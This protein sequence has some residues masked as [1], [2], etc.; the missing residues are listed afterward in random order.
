MDDG[1]SKYDLLVVGGGVNGAG[2][3]RDAAGRGLRTLLCEQHDLAAHTSSASTKLIHGGLRYLEFYDFRLVRKSLREREIVL[4]SAPHIVRPMRFVLPHDAHLRPAWMIRAGLFLYDHLARRR[5]L[6]GSEGVNLRRHPA[7]APLAARYTKG[8]V[9][10]DAWVD[11]ARLVVITAMD[12]RAHGARILTRTRCTRLERDGNRWLATLLRADGSEMHVEASAVVN[13]TGPWVD[14]FLDGSTPVPARRHPRIVKGSHI[15]VP[16]LFDHDFAYIFQAPDRRIVFAIPYEHEY[17]LIGTT[18]RDYKDDLAT[19]A[20]ETPEVDYLLAMANRYFQR[21][22]ARSDVRWSF[23]GLRPLLADPADVATSVTRDYV[24]DVEGHGPPLLSIYGGKL[25]TYRRLA[26]DVLDMLA[27]R[28]GWSREHWTAA[29]T[30]PGGDMAGGDF[31]T[32]RDELRK[33]YP[34]LPATL[35]DRLAAAYGTRVDR[36]LGV[37]RS[38]LELGEEVLPGLHQREIEYLRSEEWAVTAEDILYRRS[39]LALHLPADAAARLDD[40]LTRHPRSDS[41]RPALV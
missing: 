28:L 1:R 26:E 16:R 33:A 40:W 14:R 37:A 41:Y 31:G 17:T 23:A 9:Y 22:L 36:L 35:L 5:R 27:A 6:P 29:A 2:V 3:A 12:A 8:F 24:L 19:P 18:E 13:A 11:D 20:I 39:K 7:G 4:G 25:T 30:L 10:S 32:F 21:E 34:R 15:V 38:T